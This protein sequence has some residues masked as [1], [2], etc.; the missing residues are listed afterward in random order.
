M[1]VYRGLGDV[2]LIISSLKQGLMQEIRCVFEIIYD[3]Q[4]DSQTQRVLLQSTTS[5]L[6]VSTPSSHH[7]PLQ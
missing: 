6:H 3:I 2:I 5:G 4:T 1:L 7:Q